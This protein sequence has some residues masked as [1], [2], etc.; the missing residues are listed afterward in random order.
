MKQ[1]LCQ[2]HNAVAIT[3]VKSASSV[4]LDFSA[5]SN[6]QGQKLKLFFALASKCNF[7]HLLLSLIVLLKDFFL[8]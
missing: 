8:G 6:L 2:G 1:N 5:P 3:E 4:S 7:S